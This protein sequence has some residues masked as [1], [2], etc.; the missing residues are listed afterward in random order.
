MD[1]VKLHDIGT[2]VF[3]AFE[4]LLSLDG[5]EQFPW[6]R[7]LTDEEQRFRLWAHSI[8]LHQK[9]HASL[10]YRVRDAI[11]IKKRLAQVLSKLQEH[12]ENVFAIA[13]GERCPF[14]LD[15][16]I[17]ED[18]D[19]QDS[20]GSDSESHADEQSHSGSQSSF[21][22]I[23]FRLH[24]LTE[25]L[26]SLYG[27]A[28]RIRNPRNRPQ[29]PND[30]L[31]KHVPP[32]IRASYI[33]EREEAEIAVIAYAQRQQLIE[34][35]PREGTRLAP[36]SEELIGQYATTSHWLIRRTGIANARR[37]QQ[38]TYW[39]GHA[40]RLSQAPVQNKLTA[41]R[42]ERSREA[43]ENQGTH[44]AQTAITAVPS[45]ATSAT[46]LPLDL[47]SPGDITS[48]ISHQSRLSTVM[49]LKGEK[50]EWP[51]PPI[52]PTNS[53]Y[54]TCP[55][56]KILCPQ[57][58][59]NKDAWRIHLIHDLQPYH[60]TYEDC[61]DPHRIY[62]TRQ[63]WIDH[64]SQH[65]RVWHC[66][67]HSEEFETQP[68]YVDH[69]KTSHPEA[70]DEHFSPELISSAVGPSLKPHRDCPFCP[71]A[72]SDVTKME[73]HIMFHLERCAMIALP[74]AEDDP[75]GENGSDH[76]SD[77][78][79]VQHRGRQ[80]SI[81]LDFTPDE[82]ESFLNFCY[83]GDSPVSGPQSPNSELADSESDRT[84]NS[85]D[86]TI[87]N[88]KESPSLKAHQYRKRGLESY[89]HEQKVTETNLKRLEGQY[90]VEAPIWHDVVL[91][92]NHIDLFK[93]TKHLDCLFGS[94]EYQVT[95]AENGYLMRIPRVL[96]ED[97]TAYIENIIHIDSEI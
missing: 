94:G 96:S 41:L 46:E 93:L 48:A 44:G 28:T 5:A 62:G 30:Q 34:I 49:D 84:N 13:K 6:R 26:D 61:R 89:S 11:I 18:S 57:R 25:S 23:D 79:E 71:T 95:R 65:S 78:H 72:F 76:P 21:H 77:S 82:E 43:Y 1:S 19:D 66:Q 38:F 9:G 70:T 12:L 4:E 63:D 17:D 15:I 45:L 90:G 74:L 22:E 85:P 92:Q 64:E 47:T 53:R 37:R 52:Q 35:T 73:R 24:S 88:R 7:H 42:P 86:T 29:R 68:E 32:D 51:A 40:L 31:Y 81:A 27:L 87:A 80:G 10:D 20:T 91:R 69:L 2:K 14:E 59:L 54:F 3:T 36:S 8:G 56:C 75:N 97:E 58:Y 16:D 50:L 39:K 55:Y 67:T 60:C 83:R 33:K